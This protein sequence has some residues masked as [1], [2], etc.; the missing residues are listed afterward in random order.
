MTLTEAHR[1]IHYKVTGKRK[2]ILKGTNRFN[3]YT[4]GINFALQRLA[5][6]DGVQWSFFREI[7]DIGVVTETDTY[8]AKE[9]QQRSRKPGDRISIRNQ[10]DTHSSYYR[11]VDPSQLRSAPRSCAFTG[12]N[13]KFYKKFEA[14]DEEIGGRI[15]VPHYTSPP[16]IDPITIDADTYE[17]PGID[18]LYI[19]ALTAYDICNNSQIRKSKAAQYYNEGQD[20]LAAM[21]LADNQV[22]ILRSTYTP[23]GRTD[24]GF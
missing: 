18:P 11:I 8:F 15:L 22:D 23:A 16:L 21:I 20:I 13:L 2:D 19:I 17:L 6:T 5:N 14:D 12:H 3:D 24:F 7:L 9:V 4:A 10:L 1:L